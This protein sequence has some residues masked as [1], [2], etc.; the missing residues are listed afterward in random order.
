MHALNVSTSFNMSWLEKAF[1]DQCKEKKKINIKQ[2]QQVHLTLSS[3]K[4]KIKR[5]LFS[6]ITCYGGLGVFCLPQAKQA[7]RED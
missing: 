5:A 3:L 1:L 2:K 4:K 7:H 6:K